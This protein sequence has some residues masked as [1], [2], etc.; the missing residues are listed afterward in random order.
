MS[1]KSVARPIRISDEMIVYGYCVYAE[2]KEPGVTA[3]EVLKRLTKKP[4]RVIWR[5][6]SRARN[7][8]LIECGVSTRTGWPTQK[9]YD[10]LAAAA[11]GLA[12]K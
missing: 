1:R 11:A 5:A 12:S 9:G 4:M 10:L 2:S 7:R 8:G 3:D 6:I